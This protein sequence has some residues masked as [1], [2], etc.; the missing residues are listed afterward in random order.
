MPAAPIDHEKIRSVLGDGLDG[1]TTLPAE[2]YTSQAVFDWETEHFFENGWVCIG[3]SDEVG[4]PGDQKAV[5]I[6]DEGILLVRDENGH[7]NAFYNTCRHRGHELL[8]PGATRNV[9]AIKCPYHA[10]VYGLDG[11]L[12]GAP[13]FGEV[14]GFDKADY[15]LVAARVSYCTPM[16]RR[17]WANTSPSWSS[18]TRPT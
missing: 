6:G 16:L 1:S 14:A 18:R 12:N 4:Q 2:A 3:R 13:R 5:R 17:S 8:E 11:A 10:W 7:L 9:R 15:P